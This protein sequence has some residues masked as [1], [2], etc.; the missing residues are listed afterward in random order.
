[1]AAHFLDEELQQKY[2]GTT[3]LATDRVL[4]PIVAVQEAL[5]FINSIIYKSHLEILRFELSGFLRRLG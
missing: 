1:M 3:I 2:R 5:R 4:N